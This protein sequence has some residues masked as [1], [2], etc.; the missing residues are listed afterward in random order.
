MKK[1][2]TM[3]KLAVIALLLGAVIGPWR[4]AHA[5]DI[6]YSADLVN[7]SCIAQN[8]NYD[9]PLFGI[10]SLSFV[11]SYST[12][13]S[14]ARTFT[15]GVKSTASITVS[16][17][18]LSPATA[19]VQITISTGG[20]ALTGS[21]ITLNG[22]NFREGAGKEWLTTA[23]TSTVATRLAAAIDLDANIVATAVNNVVFASAAFVGA[24]PNS[25]A[26]T[27]STVGM[28]LTGS[29]F[30]KGGN[31]RA[32]IVINDT[33]FDADIA[34]TVG[35]SSMATAKNISDAF[36]ANASIAG[37][38]TSTWAAS[39]VVTATANLTGINNWGIFVSTPFAL[40]IN[41][42]STA[43]TDTFKGGVATKVSTTNDTVDITTHSYG[44]GLAVLYTTSPA[45]SGIGG[46]V[47]GTTYYVVKMSY[48]QIKLAT[49]KANA[50]AG[51]VIDLTSQTGNGTYTL[52]P[53]PRTDNPAFKWQVSNDS[54]SW[55]DLN[56]TSVTITATSVTGW[57]FG[58]LAYKYLRLAFTSATTGCANIRA[59]G[60]GG[61]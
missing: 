22:V 28:T 58:A 35:A 15:D 27:S 54:S 53:S 32:R 52:T 18:T 41:T 30:F 16:S 49:S 29:G 11:A 2:N 48:D 57:D 61:R 38:F 47:N 12:T 40:R 36:M 43:S 14:A 1:E 10:G 60:S 13:T 20:T 21:T 59:N 5:T 46:L 8:T 26:A 31:D 50:T 45:T 34:F 42:S 23:S 7:D 4:S 25:W 39:G 19:W 51:T 6:V 33:V 44:T 56:V 17:N 37:M 55:F 24:F 3:K 9:Q